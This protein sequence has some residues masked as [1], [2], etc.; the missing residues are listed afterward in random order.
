MWLMSQTVKPLTRPL[1]ESYTT[2]RKMTRNL[3]KL[4]SAFMSGAYTLVR[5]HFNSRD[6]EAIGPQM[7]F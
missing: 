2:L 6:N 3:L 1:H 7:R 4:R 5:E